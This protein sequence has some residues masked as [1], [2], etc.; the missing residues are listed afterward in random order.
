MDPLNRAQKYLG[1]NTHSFNGESMVARPGFAMFNI[2]FAFSIDNDLTADKKLALSPGLHS[3]SAA[4][5]TAGYSCDAVI[6]DGAVITDL[7]LS[8]ENPKLTVNFFKNFLANRR[9]LVEKIR[10]TSDQESQ[11]QKTIEIGISTPASVEGTKTIKINPYYNVNQQ[12]AKT[13]DMV[14]GKHGEQFWMGPDNVA[15]LN[16]A[17]SSNLDIIISGKIE[18]PL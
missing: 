13:V 4:L 18:L 10:M 2:D 12:S 17:K 15:I 8:A 1:G 6:G 16:V 11:F 7:T 14:L 3:S 9:F 5:A